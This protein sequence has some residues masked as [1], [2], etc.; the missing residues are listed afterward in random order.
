MTRRISYPTVDLALREVTDSRAFERAS[1]YVLVEQ[2]PTLRIT[3]PTADGGKDLRVAPLGS[4]LDDVRVMVSIEGMWHRKLDAELDK[5]EKLSASDRPAD[6]LFVTNRNATETAIGR[7]KERALQLGVRLEV[8]GHSQ[9]VVALNEPRLRWVAEFEL[10]AEPLGPRSL[11]SGSAFSRATSKTT[12][13]F[14]AT[15]IGQDEV[16]DA[17]RRELWSE[18]AHASRILVLEGPGGIGKTRLAVDVSSRDFTTSV[19]PMGV[20]LRAGEIRDVPAGVPSVIVVDDVHRAEDLSGIRALFMDER[21]DGTRIVM[22]SRPGHTARALAAASLSEYRPVTIPMDVL[23][24]EHIA[25]I[26]EGWGIDDARFA[27]TVVEVSRGVPLVAH[28]MCE[29]AIGQGR[30]DGRDMVDV[31]ESRLSARLDAHD[32]GARAVAVALAMASTSTISMGDSEVTAGVGVAGLAQYAR[33]VSQMPEPA[34]IGETLELLAD[35][36][37]AQVTVA[38]ARP[39][40]RDFTYS[41]KPDLLAATLVGTALTAQ[42]GVQVRL[43]GLLEII[44]FPGEVGSVTVALSETQGRRVITYGGETVLGRLDSNLATHQLSILA[45]AAAIAGDDEVLERLSREVIRLIPQDPSARDWR[46]VF[47][48]AGTVAPYVPAIFAKLVSQFERR[49]PPRS[50]ESPT[51]WFDTPT[52]IDDYE[53]EQLA[54]AVVDV[55][56]SY[57]AG[58]VSAATRL[59][60]TAG[61][62]S[63]GAGTTAVAR[64]NSRD[65][66][67]SRS[68]KG[69]VLPRANEPWIDALQRRLEVLGEVEQWVATAK[70]SVVGGD[71]PVDRRILNVALSALLEAIDPICETHM[72]GSPVA[73]DVLVMSSGQLPATPATLD[74]LD[75]VGAAIAELIKDLDFEGEGRSEPDATVR[76]FIQLPHEWW[77]VGR[78]GLPFAGGALHTKTAK[79]LLAQGRRVEQAF[80]DRW[81]DLP[82]WARY[83]L[84]RSVD[85][86]RPVRTLQQRARSGS[87]V[88]TAAVADTELTDLIALVPLRRPSSK[89]FRR[90]DAG[91]GDS[92]ART[93]AR[94]VAGRNDLA[95]ALSLLRTAAVVQRNWSLYD[96]MSDFVDAVV[97]RV[98]DEDELAACLEAVMDGPA[99]ASP[100]RLVSDLLERFPE[101]VAAYL[102]D[103]ARSAAHVEVLSEVVGLVGDGALRR[104]LVETTLELVL[105]L[106]RHYRGEAESASSV[107][108][109]VHAQSDADGDEPMGGTGSV[110]RDA[111]DRGTGEPGV[112]AGLKALLPLLVRPAT[113]IAAG[114]VSVTANAVGAALGAAR[115][116][117]G[118]GHDRTD[119][120]RASRRRGDDTAPGAEGGAHAGPPKDVPTRG[121]LDALARAWIQMTWRLPDDADIAGGQPK[122]P[123]GW[124]VDALVR[125]GL[126][127]P[128]ALTG[129]VLL[130]STRDARRTRHVARRAG[131]SPEEPS[132]FESQDGLTDAQVS[133]LLAVLE[134]ALAHSDGQGWRDLVADWDF[135]ASVAEMACLAPEELGA[136]LASWCVEQDGSA[137]RFPLDWDDP[138]GDLD[139][140]DRSAFGLALSARLDEKLATIEH[141]DESNAGWARFEVDQ[142]LRKLLHDSSEWTEMVSTWLGS[143]DTVSRAVGVLAKMWRSEEWVPLVLRLIGAHPDDDLLEAV[144]AGMVPT[145]WGPNIE[146]DIEPR[147][148]ALSHLTSAAEG[149]AGAPAADVEAF[150]ASARSAL[151]AVIDEYR[152][153]AERRRRG[154]R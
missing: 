151:Q 28:A 39:G 102:R 87:P 86:V 66:V 54:T 84:A 9:L 134:R 53:L 36:G 91:R 123:S 131:A 68:I 127:G 34:V 129:E 50:S 5:I 138:I 63:A 96:P 139:V 111:G 150:V 116:L 77:G 130:R 104:E 11:L 89:Q 90:A 4:E 99:V 115:G 122:A 70:T 95:A 103:R 26:V 59:A 71:T 14:D 49:W 112:T 133:G 10:D 69:V 147:F 118:S 108:A 106:E 38:S 51:F 81:P 23:P 119:G 98:L 142:V 74:I 143:Q 93:A 57:G 92:R 24:R 18:G 120:S 141:Q 32:P 20:P 44:G 33:A 37:L 17:L 149:N 83:E 21:F 13:G 97:A 2:Y 82:L 16:I 78:R 42:R 80:A 52:S 101:P 137:R 62:R 61:I 85:D 22:T 55:V 114:T 154:Y 109:Q 1:F 27:T 25:Q 117:G 76:S 128:A 47:T 65:T 3:A 58:D 48:L 144:I 152:S 19:L 56:R 136:M 125:M 107:Q 45:Q 146:E 73:A 12:P 31:L 72:M 60:L 40:D 15:F 100:G 153:D 29:A 126:E 46:V 8:V 64:S 67:V 30:F 41:V 79:A 6:A 140:E 43:S 94:S 113:R 135:G 121:E 105:D 35:V 75:R 110:S 145:G 124:R 7:R 88:A 132:G 148:T